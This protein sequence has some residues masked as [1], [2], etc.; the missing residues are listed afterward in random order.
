MKNYSLVKTLMLSAA[1]VTGLQCVGVASAGENPDA[2]LKEGSFFGQM[3]YRYETVDQDGIANHATASTVRTNLGFKTGAYQGFTS[4]AELQLVTELGANDFNNTVNGK[5]AYPVVADP[6]TAEFNR[7]WVAWN[8]DNGF[9]VKVGRQAVNLDNQRFIG[10]VGWRQNDQTYDA[11]LVY[12]TGIEN[13]TAHY[14]HVVNVNRI[15]GDDHVLGDLDTSTHL[16]R[17]GYKADDL[18]DVAAYAYL[19]EVDLAPAL[20]AQTYGLRATGKTAISDDWSFAYEAE[21]AQQSEYGNNPNDFDENYYHISPSISG[22]GLTLQAGYEVLGGN[23]TNSFQTPLATLHKFN[24]WADKFLATNANGLEDIYGK[25]VYKI[26]GTDTQLDGTKFV[27]M[28][29]NFDGDKSGEYGS[30]ID[31]SVGKSFKLPEGLPSEKLN[32]L[33]KFAD[34]DADD[35]PY[36]DTQKLWL[37]MSVNF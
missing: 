37:Q 35:A 2:I 14:G 15:F 10:T 33:V 9:G 11:A 28:Y 6:K 7:A 5:T 8:S 29:H 13:L 31:L 27:A 12:Y 21:Y 32:V 17:L 23:G 4:L 30:E 16:V 25:V 36:T 22:H 19:W 34:Y 20:S 3:R 1:F 18:L 26:S 24:G